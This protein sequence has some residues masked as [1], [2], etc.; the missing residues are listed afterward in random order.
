MK[1][2]TFDE[3]DDDSSW[4]GHHYNIDWDT[5]EYR[6]F[7]EPLPFVRVY[8][9]GV[10]RV[11]F[12]GAHDPDWR[13]RILK[14]MDLQFVATDSFAGKRFYHP[15]SGTRIP[16][17]HIVPRWLLYVPELDSVYSMGDRAD[18]N[19]IYF[20]AP[21]ALPSP[22]CGVVVQTPNRAGHKAL[23]AELQN[24]TSLGETLVGLHGNYKDI[25]EEEYSD[26]H[27]RLSRKQAAIHAVS[28]IKNISTDLTQLKTQQICRGLIENKNEVKKLLWKTS[29]ICSK[30]NYLYVK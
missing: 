27:A 2:I 15:L 18:R 25:E 21:H 28:D 29:H 20:Y 12:N 6:K 23:I 24:H 8:E 10:I 19:P 11:S 14:E 13:D 4:C 22:S 16:A 17:S 26:W 3:L 30:P 9:C 5:N 7:R 1:W